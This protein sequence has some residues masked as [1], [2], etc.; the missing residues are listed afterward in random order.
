MSIFRTVLVRV[1]YFVPNSE[2]YSP[3]P[4]RRLL[5][6]PALLAPA[7]VSHN[8]ARAFRSRYPTHY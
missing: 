2:D 4:T 8:L 5:V 1:L 7:N 3:E 6:R